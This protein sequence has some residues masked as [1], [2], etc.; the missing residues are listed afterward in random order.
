[1]KHFYT[2]LLLALMAMTSFAQEKN[3]TTYVMMDFNQ[4]PWNYPLTTTMKGWGPNYTDETGAIFEDK[5][6]DWPIAEGSDQKVKVT[7]YAVDLDEYTKPAVYAL[8]DND[9]DS[10]TAGYTGDK[11]CV[12]FTNPGTSMRF[13]SPEGYKFGKMVFYNFHSSNF[14][15]GNEYEEEYEYQFEESTFKHNLKVWKPTSPKKSQY[16]METW[17]G[18]DKDILFDYPYFTA[19][20]LKIDIRL[21]PDNT[22]AIR[23][24]GNQQSA[25][26][27]YFDLQG[28]RLHAVQSKGIYVA[29]GKKIV[30]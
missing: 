2:T 6:F 30:K 20:F 15:V 21:V 14:M 4:N 12:L 13:E 17:Q 9:N 1:M 23:K 26:S 7:V 11:I 3:D 5:R 25:D 28:R 19:H 24:I 27:K 18:D 22:A 8:V 29:D 10:R 16:D